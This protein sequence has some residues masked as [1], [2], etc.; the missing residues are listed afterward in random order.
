MQRV[1]LLADFLQ[2]QGPWVILA[3]HKTSYSRGPDGRFLPAITVAS[4]T[5]G[6][7]T[8]LSS[9]P[10]L[11]SSPS[12]ITLTLTSSDQGGNSG[13][14]TPVYPPPP[15]STPL[16]PQISPQELAAQ[17]K[18]QPVDMADRKGD[19]PFTRED[20]DTVDPRDFL[21]RTQRY[22]MLTK[23][24]DVDKIDYFE[25][26]LKSRSAAEPLQSPIFGYL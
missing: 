3:K 17:P 25:T 4:T 21:K 20:D 8:P 6:T 13:A 22:L 9:L 24:E 15:P 10:S 16:I 7:F 5:S 26:W 11:S 18:P 1:N 23:W 12:L 2:L 14:S 19:E